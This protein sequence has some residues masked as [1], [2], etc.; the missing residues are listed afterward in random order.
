VAGE[1]VKLSA[2]SVTIAAP[3]P[4]ELATFYAQVLGVDVINSE[5]PGDDEPETAG[6]AQIRTASLTL[7]FE[8]ERCWEPPVWPAQ[9]GRQVATQHLDIWVTDLEEAVGWAVECGARLANAQPQEDVRV[10]VDPAGHPFCL[11]R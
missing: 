1:R 6:W 3:D 11:F 10:M 5:P 4:L 2:T 8:F 7:N 9:T